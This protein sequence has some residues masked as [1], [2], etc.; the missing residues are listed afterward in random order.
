MGFAGWA[1]NGWKAPVGLP[2]PSVPLSLPSALI[3]KGCLFSFSGLKNPLTELVGCGGGGGRTQRDYPP[4]ACEF[5]LHSTMKH[6]SSTALP[7]V[8][9]WIM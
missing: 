2:Y 4:A 5:L 6:R 8:L 9:T 7:T 3:S 1:F